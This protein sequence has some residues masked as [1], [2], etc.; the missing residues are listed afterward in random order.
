MQAA[1][2][3]PA[4]RENTP[5]PPTPPAVALILPGPQTPF[6]Q[7]AEAVR[8]GFV[9]A[10]SASAELVAIE[11]VEVDATAD[12][13]IKALQAA[14]ERGV[15]LAVGPL[16]RDAVMGVVE[17][18]DVGIPV[19]LLAMPDKSAVIPAGQ[20]A[21]GLSAEDEAAFL[22]REMLRDSELANPAT[23]RH[24]VVVGEGAFAR[25]TGAA[26]LAAL[27]E[28]GASS[29]TLD[30]PAHDAVGIAREIGKLAPASVLLALDPPDAVQVRTRLAV[31]A[32]LYATSQINPGPAGGAMAAIDLDGVRFVDLPWMIDSLRGPLAK[33]DRAPASYSADQQRLYALGIDAFRVASAWIRGA[34]AVEFD[35]AT[36]ALRVDRTRSARVERKPAFAVFREGRIEPI[37][38]LKDASNPE[39]AG[40]VLENCADDLSATKPREPNAAPAG[41]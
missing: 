15:R 23:R 30:F 16:T 14:R 7:V 6:A 17:R 36:G 10:R 32:P 26:L 35:G 21:F 3:S 13:A 25:R 24:V 34:V 29:T 37:D 20:F 5:I 12:A 33:F 39:S 4:S 40:C 11:V 41:R 9:A 31:D 18:G 8:E 1:G 28:A 38:N 27:R 19:L 2:Q 22:V